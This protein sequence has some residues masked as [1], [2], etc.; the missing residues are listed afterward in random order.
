[1]QL[2]SCHGILE[3]LVFRLRELHFVFAMLKVIGKYIDETGLDKILV[4]SEIYGENTLKQILGGKGMKM[5]V[6]AHPTLYLALS[7]VFINAWYN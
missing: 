5:S 3:E 2:R 7:R 1:M 6:E 4:V